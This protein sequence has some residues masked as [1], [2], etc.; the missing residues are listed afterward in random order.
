MLSCLFKNA[1]ERINN[2]RSASPSSRQDNSSSDNEEEEEK[3]SGT[4]SSHD[5]MEDNL[6]RVYS[7]L[8]YTVHPIEKVLRGCKKLDKFIALVLTFV[9]C[10]SG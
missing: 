9:L 6:V 1:M 5:A 2:W 3:G 7:T 4:R 10:L 8:L